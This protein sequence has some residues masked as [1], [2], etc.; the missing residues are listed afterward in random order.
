[1]GLSIKN[2][3]NWGIVCWVNSH[4]AVVDSLWRAYRKE[5]SPRQLL[6][7]KFHSSSTNTIYSTLASLNINSSLACG[8]RASGYVDHKSIQTGNW[9][10]VFDLLSVCPID[11][12]YL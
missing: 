7:E 2:G 8:S 10:L 12:H 4:S 6:G 9:G 1:M 11:I 3:D 5:E